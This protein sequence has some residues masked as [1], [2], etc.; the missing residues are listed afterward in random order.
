MPHTWRTRPDPFVDVWDEICE[1]L[2]A[3]PERTAKSLFVELQQRYPGR[4]PDVQLRTLQRRIKLWREKTILAFDDQWLQQE[5]LIA[6]VQPPILRVVG[7]RA[8][9]LVAGVTG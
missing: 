5:V 4:F 9:V 3:T 2:S 8:G 6:P 1:R 7:E